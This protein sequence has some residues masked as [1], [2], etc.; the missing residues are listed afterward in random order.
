MV[1]VPTLL[2]QYHNAA[3]GFLHKFSFDPRSKL[4]LRPWARPY[5]TY[6]LHCTASSGTG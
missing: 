3:L 6:I 5:G 2:C 1:Q 4:S